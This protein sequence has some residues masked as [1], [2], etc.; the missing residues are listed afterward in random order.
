MTKKIDIEGDYYRLNE[1]GIINLASTVK[2]WHDTSGFFKPEDHLYF[3]S[4]GDTYS[5]EKDQE[6]ITALFN[7]LVKDGS[8]IKIGEELVNAKSIQA[9]HYNGK[10]LETIIVGDYKEYKMSE[11]EANSIISVLKG[12][13]RFALIDDHIVNMNKVVN[14]WFKEAGMF[15]KDRLKIN[16]LGDAEMYINMSKKAAQQA[17]ET[18]AQRPQFKII[19]GEAVNI[20]LAGNIYAENNELHLYYPGTSCVVKTDGTVSLIIDEIHQQGSYQKVND[21]LI[22]PKIISLAEKDGAGFLS[23]A[24][25]T[26]NILSE[27]FCVK[28][29]GGD[30]EQSYKTLEEDADLVILPEGLVNINAISLAYYEA[31]KLHYKVGADDYTQ[32]MSQIEAQDILD[33]LIAHEKFMNI[34]GKAVNIQSASFFETTEKGLQGRFGRTTEKFPLTAE[35]SATIL[36][37][38]QQHSRVFKKIMQ[39]KYDS[40]NI[41]EQAEATW[42]P[43]L[44]AEIYEEIDSMY[45]TNTVVMCAAVSVMVTSNAGAASL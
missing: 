13:K 42:D 24:K 1:E 23:S 34:S 14:V 7:H 5:K 3:K 25:I 38:I 16:F 4:T 15:S 2:L 18:S 11:L 41:K 40:F 10:K 17:I 22:N 9:L 6:S 32:K 43:D 35:Q 27:D 8:F 21:E 19:H 28:G 26:F 12:Q 31:G 44:L 37:K 29:D 39:G 33:Q 20:A 30:L 45:T 36:Q